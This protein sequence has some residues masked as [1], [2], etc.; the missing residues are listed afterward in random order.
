MFSDKVDGMGVE[1]VDVPAAT[2]ALSSTAGAATAQPI[3]A[4]VVKAGTLNRL[5]CLL[6][7]KTS[8]PEFMKCFLMCHEQFTS[9]LVVLTK[10]LERFWVPP[11][12]DEYEHAKV[13][14]LNVVNVVKHWLSD[15]P[16]DWSPEM[17]LMLERFALTLDAPETRA[18]AVQ[19]DTA[20]AKKKVQRAKQ[21]DRNPP[22]PIVPREIFSS[23]LQLA[24]VHPEE[25]ARQLSMYEFQIFQNIRPSELLN[26]AWSKPKLKHKARNVLAL[27][28]CFNAF[29]QW[30]VYWIMQHDTLEKRAKAVSFIV[31]LADA[32]YRLN[33][34]D[35][36][37]ALLAA[38][39]SA[40]IGRLKFTF[41]R[42][43][44]S[45]LE[46]KRL[47]ES[48]CSRELS[49]KSYR[50][51]IATANPP[52]VPY[53]GLYLTDLVF[54][55]E[56]NPAHVASADGRARLIHFAKA[57]HT[58]RVISNSIQRYQNVP[59]NFLVIQQIQSL[60]TKL[61][62]IT[63]SEAYRLSLEFEPRGAELAD[64]K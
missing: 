41:A 19:F 2:V 20:L 47:L 9:S 11:D 48:A 30:G 28:D 14:Q 59:Y 22:K 64:I 57:M 53:L 40:P 26:L 1:E 23:T 13:V 43:S 51:A 63:E 42:L 16:E 18:F 60:F 44:P 33:N 54:I 58:Y 17:R 52:V 35:S 34:F 62:S 4:R 56:G 21:F 31:K 8:N 10:L 39:N 5:V 46:K 61:P 32:L 12:A 7:S 3:G 38:L 24:N 36:L 45:V 27:I 50:A 37:M 55:E 25:I 6:T 15:Y 49:Y 29:S